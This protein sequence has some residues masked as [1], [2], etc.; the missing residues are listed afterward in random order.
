M[1][2]LCRAVNDRA[3]AL[4]AAACG[5]TPDS[6]PGVKNAEP[7][8]LAADADRSQRFTAVAASEAIY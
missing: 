1:I 2:S 6:R 7:G 4:N 8:A 3:Q 5:V